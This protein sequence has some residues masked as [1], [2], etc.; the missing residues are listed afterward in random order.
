M[1]AATRHIPLLILGSGPAGYTSA[2]YAGQGLGAALG[3]LLSLWHHSAPFYFAGGLC[4]VNA[5]LIKTK[6]RETLC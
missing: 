1:S 4:L 6:V 2:I 5:W 3:G